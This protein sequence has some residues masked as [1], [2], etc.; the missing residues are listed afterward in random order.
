MIK[1]K[2]KH[3]TESWGQG[4]GLS[5]CGNSC[6]EADSEQPSICSASRASEL[7]PGRLTLDLLTRQLQFSYLEEM[8]WTN[9]TKD[10]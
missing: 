10:S 7:E 3:P 5:V 6:E 9:I 4:S 2:K 8:Q 1:K